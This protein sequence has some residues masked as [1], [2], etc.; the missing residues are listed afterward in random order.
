MANK[1][2]LRQMAD[3]N[4]PTSG[5][6]IK[7]LR[8]RKWAALFASVTVG[9]LTTVGHAHAQYAGQI[10]S[11]V[12]DSKT[13][14]VLSQT[15]PDL[16]RYPASLTKLMTLYMTFNAL[17]AGAISL[18]QAVPVSIHASTMEPSKLGLVPGSRLTVEQAV[19]ALVTKSANDAACALGELIGGGSEPQFAAMMTQ[20][21]HAMGMN[22]TL[23]RNA[24]GLPDPDQMTTARDLATLGRRLIAD[25]PEYYHYFSTPAFR[26]HGRYIPN[27]NPM[28][29]VYAGADGMKTGYTQEAG[30]N[31]VTSAI[32]DNVRLVGVVMGASSN[33][34]R[35]LVMANQ[36]DHGFDAEGVAPVARP[37]LVAQAPSTLRHRS[38]RGALIIAAANRKHTPLEVAEA[39]TARRH[40]AAITKVSHGRHATVIGAKVHTISTPSIRRSTARQSTAH[41]RT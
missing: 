39:P 28:L 37:L 40:H 22:Q 15:N 16:R 31:L 18:N 3:G 32:R 9:A 7:N 34:Q 14:A 13:G 23:F 36:L 5:K 17:R 20:Q 1:P 38:H 27:H 6:S 4:R 30:R 25:F 11:I 12:M 29:K 10:S 2:A 21:A 41:N 33:T 24:S 26:F 8:L 19:L 35:S